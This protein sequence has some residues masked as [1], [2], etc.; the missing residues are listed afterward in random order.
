MRF[1]E[2]LKEHGTIGFV[3]PSFGCATEPYYTAFAHARE[4]FGQMGYHT[5]MGP[6]C[7]VDKG[8][9]ISNDPALCGKE[10]N[11]SYCGT[12]NDVIISCGGGELMCEVVPYIDFAGIAQA[13]PKW[14][15]GFSDNTNF[16]FL[17]ATIA[18][19]AAIYG[20]CAAAFGMEPWH[21]AVQDALDLLCGKIT[22]VHNYDLWEKESV[23]DEEHP[24]AP[25][26][27]TEPVELK[28]FP[29]GAENVTMEG[30]LIGGCMDCLVN[31]LGTRF[32]HVKEFQ[33]RYK[34]DGFL[35]FLEAC[36]LHVMSIRRAIWQMKEAGWF[37]HVKGFL[38]GRPVC[39]GEEAFGIDH[40]RAVTDLLAEYQVPVIMDLDIG[41]MAPMMP[42]VT[43]AMAKAHVQGN[44]FVLDYEWRKNERFE[45]I[46]GRYSCG[47]HG[48]WKCSSSG[49]GVC[50]RGRGCTGR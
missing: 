24:L 34:E 45:K 25:Y 12:E 19:T 38:I 23:K 46:Y 37:S 31:L 13:K 42:V 36:D 28:V 8:I 29:Q 33:E 26:H 32:D 22:R 35:W 48:S 7:L 2:F 43:G 3:A 18:D 17:S 41:H 49:T 30:R 20:P 5:Q 10:L 21:P 1:P 15:M 11:E 39:F 6:N 14:Y 16:T 27:V 9:G 40:Y 50:D 47:R 4:R 44:T